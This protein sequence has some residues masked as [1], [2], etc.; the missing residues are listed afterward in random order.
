MSW[1]RKFWRDR[2]AEMDEAA[3]VIP[4][5]LLVTFGL[6][7]FGMLGYASVSA[8]NAANYGAR[9]GSV[10]QANP[11]GVAASS[12]NRMLSG[13]TVGSYQVSVSGGGSPGSLIRVQVRYQVPNYFA[14]LANLFGVDLPG[15][16]SGNANADFRQEGW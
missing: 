13:T 9:M 4:V 1:L 8:G 16:I 11:Q 6:I 14:S 10:A 15:V 2:R 5:L 3:F 12:T 7:N